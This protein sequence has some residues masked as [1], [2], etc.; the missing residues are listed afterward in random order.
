L[1]SAHR[2]RLPIPT[3]VTIPAEAL[4]FNGHRYLLVESLG[5]WNQAK[6]KA[7]AMGGHL[8]TITSKEERFWIRENAWIKRTKTQPRSGHMFLGATSD[9]RDGA[10]TWTTGEPFDPSLWIGT[11]PQ[12]PGRGLMWMVDAQWGSVDP[13]DENS[14][15]YYFL[16]EWDSLGPTIGSESSR[17]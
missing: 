14:K 2:R 7:E 3:T 8:A 9:Q 6:S 5:T 13:D 16:V 10:W 15:A 11:I 17:P 1:L 12:E 4:A